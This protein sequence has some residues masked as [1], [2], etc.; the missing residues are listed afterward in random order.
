MATFAVKLGTYALGTD[1]AVSAIDIITSRR[2][3]QSPIIRSNMTIIPEGKMQPLKISLKGTLV[4]SD[5][6]SFRT[7]LANLR[8]ILEVSKQDFY[9]DDERFTR[10]I[11]TGLD[12]SFVTTDFCNYAVNFLGELPYWLN[13]GTSYH[14]TVPTTAVSYPL[15][16]SGDAR[17]PL[18]IV[19]SAPQATTISDNIQFENLTLGLLCKYRGLLGTGQTLVIDSGYD[20]NNVPTFKVELDGVDAMSAF[21]GDFMAV[22]TG[23][24][25]VEYTG[26]A[27]GT[28]TAYWRQGYSA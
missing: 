24:N 22:T 5:Y 10:V 15:N 21:E 18:K 26:A 8:S 28:F 9:L 20:A 17:I 11:H 1:A 2:I 25:W 3:S 4:G 14:T 7:A 12:Y 13:V 23:T 19:L 16:N 27:V 6:T